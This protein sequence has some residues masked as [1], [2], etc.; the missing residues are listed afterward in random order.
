[1]GKENTVSINLKKEKRNTIVSKLNGIKALGLVLILVLGIV[2]IL[3]LGVLYK[4]MKVLESKTLTNTE[5]IWEMRR[6][7][8]SEVSYILAGLIEDDFDTMKEYLAASE[9]EA[10]RT[11]EVLELYK[12]NHEVDPQLVEEVDSLFH[13][14]NALQTKMKDLIMLNTEKSDQ[15]AFEVCME[16]YLPVY[17]VLT[18]KLPILGDLQKELASEQIVKSLI[19][20]IALIVF[21]VLC[22]MAATIL[23]GNRI[24]ALVKNIL[25]PLEQMEKASIALSEGDFSM[26]ITHESEDEFGR[27]CSNMKKSFSILKSVLNEIKEEFSQLAKGDLTVRPSMTFPGELREIEV[28]VESLIQNLNTS[29]YEIKSSA[30]TITAGSEQFTGVSQDLAQGATEQTQVLH[31]V[32]ESF[33]A[34]AKQIRDTSEEAENADKMVKKTSQI[35]KES[36]KKM[37]E[38]LK[39]MEDISEIT[40]SMSR[41]I[42]LIDGIASQTNLLALNAAIEAARAGEAGRGFAVVAEQVKI[43]AQQTSDSAKETSVLIERSLKTVADGNEIAKAT[44]TALEEIAEYITQV[45]EVVDTIASVAQ[46]EAKE[47]AKIA[48]DLETVSTVAQ[49]NS[50]T[51]EE[52]AASSE[53]LA[54]QSQTLKNSVERFNLG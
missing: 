34:M 11:A 32:T 46:S 18:E 23:F 4:Q 37:D 52:I 54:A 42:E 30:E 39:A 17:G 15:E 10:K 49:A 8:E 3:G 25:V 2:A 51:S 40:E 28:S 27:V 22:V 50:A 6:N 20:F 45:S 21:V 7:I 53:E 38:M 26:E 48:D 44:N 33:S 36:Q 12:G 31:A 5:Y 47:T 29:F 43:L 19:I 1:M 14:L 16:E 24:A 9:E 41:I 13:E 35:T